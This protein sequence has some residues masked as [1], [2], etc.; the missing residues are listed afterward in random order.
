MTSPTPSTQHKTPLTSYQRTLLFFLSVATFFE[1]YDFMALAQILPNVRADLGLPDEAG[2]QMLMV[3]NA[4][5]IAAYALIR[6]ADVWG[7]KRVFLWTIVGYTLSTLATAFAPNAV[8]FSVAQFVAR[9]FLLAEYALSMV[10]A[11]EEF[12]AD[13]RGFAIGMIQGFASL[14]TIMCAAFVPLMLKIPA[15]APGVGG[16]WRNVYLIGAVPLLI[17]TFLRRGLRETDRFVQ[18]RAAATQTAQPLTRVLRGPYRNRVLL[19]GGI[20]LLT[21][22]CTQ[23]AVML[24]KEFAVHERGFT[25]SDVAKMF[26]VAAIAS[27]PCVFLLGRALDQ[28]GRRVTSVV[29][30]LALAGSTI[31]CYTLHGTVALTLSLVFGIFAASGVLPVLN[32]YT[33]ELFPTDLRADAYAWSNNLFGRAGGIVSPPLV[34]ALLPSMGWSAVALTAVFPLIALGLIL[35]QLPETRGRELE[36]TSAL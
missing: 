30:F 18:A 32:A 11:A 20:W 7:R 4:G 19:L 10:Y 15:L 35:T 26:A 24:W 29:V 33:A 23:V 16:G 21:Y 3:I 27:L 13:R 5:G 36:Q 14:G 17:V 1:G 28:L 25:D 6:K 12:P 2:P 31:G 22:M 34:Q 8:V 9:I